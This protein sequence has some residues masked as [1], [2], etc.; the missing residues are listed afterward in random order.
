MRILT[1]LLSIIDRVNKWVGQIIFPLI[2]VMTLVLV[3]EVVLR[4]VFNNP[5]KWAHELS[6]MVFGTY[7]MLGAGYAMLHK[8]H[9]GVDVFHA[10]LSPRKKAIVDLITSVLF[11]LFI[12]VM[13]Y[14]GGELA[15]DAW[16]RGKA[17]ETYWGPPLAPLLTMLPLGAFLLLLQGMA[18]FIRDL[19]TAVLGREAA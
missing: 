17:S 12:G 2:L 7:F 11:F 15:R 6:Q 9:I 13:L 16:I 1:R 18:K 19:I 8:S 14:K 4:Y 5:T 10:R 3:Y